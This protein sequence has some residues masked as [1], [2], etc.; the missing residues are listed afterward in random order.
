MSRSAWSTI[1][2]VAAA[3]LGAVWLTAWSPSAQSAPAAEPRPRVAVFFEA[4]FPAVDIEAIPEADL[5]QA[6]AGLD[7]EWLSASRLASGLS[8]ERHDVLVMPFG[9]AYPEEAWLAILR[10]LEAGGSLVNV[11]GRPFAVTVSRKGAAWQALAE[12]SAC[13]KT[14]GLTHIFQVPAATVATWAVAAA[15]PAVPASLAT[16]FRADVVFEADIRLTNPKDFP[17]EDGSD[18]PREGRVGPRD[19]RGG[20]QLP[21]LQALFGLAI[22]REHSYQTASGG[23]R[24]RIELE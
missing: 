5:R 24:V 13:Y 3:V 6:L 18:G 1:V 23:D 12:S 10:F 16:G 4:G 11:G 8:R 21:L 19:S 14:L 2:A 22:L 7:V 20:D 15:A 9:S 17:D